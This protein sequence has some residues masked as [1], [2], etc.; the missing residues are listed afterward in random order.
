MADV[1]PWASGPG[2]ILRHAL[3]L[4][5]KD[6]DTNRRLAM[7]LIDNAVE[8]MM[9]T[10]LGL[11]SRVT[12]I[13]ISRDRF[14][15]IG[16]SFPKLLDAM[17]EH[18]DDKLTG[19][20]LGQVEWYHRLRNELYHQGN[21]LTVE[22]VKVDVYAELAK[23]LYKNLFGSVIEVEEDEPMLLL[24][25]FMGTWQRVERALLSLFPKERGM[26]IFGPTTARLLQEAGGAPALSAE[27]DALRKIR[28]DVAHG[29]VERTAVT[30]DLIERVERFA[31]AVEAL[32]RR[33]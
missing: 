30:A 10:H 3:K 25:R 31:R 19:V 7:I 9:K 15:E 17:E 5:T 16:E 20:D 8:L 32:E 22:R 11:P 6:S 4:L 24:G 2:E 28:N 33:D 27:F 12:G 1:G 13:K 21:G 18:A 26:S 29:Q 23:L 14:R